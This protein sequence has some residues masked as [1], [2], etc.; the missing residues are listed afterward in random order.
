MKK[1]TDKD[2]IGFDNETYLKLESQKIL[3]R[4]DRFGK[5][6]L[7][8][9]G[10]LFDDNHASRVLPGFD[11][12]LKTRLLQSISDKTEIIFCV[13]A[14]DIEKHR[15]KSDLGLSYDNNSRNI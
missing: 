5:L 1:K 10:K 11:P 8:F 2:L 3:E 6:Y 15:T 13:S 12:N 4:L 9:G 7:E 14:I